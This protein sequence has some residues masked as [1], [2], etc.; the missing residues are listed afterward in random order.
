MVDVLSVRGLSKEY[1]AFRLDDVSFSVKKGSITGFVGRNGAGKTTTLKSILGLCKKSGGDVLFFGLPFEEN[2]WQIKKRIG[3]AGG[4]VNFYP[5]KKIREIVNVTRSFY[6]NFDEAAFARYMEKFSLDVEKCPRELSE[7][8][9]VKLNLALAL[10]HRAEL[11]I[12]DEPTSGLDP[13]S[14]EELLEIFLSLAA[15]GVSILFSTHIVSDL[16]KCA[17]HIVYLQKGGV[18]ID[19]PYRDFAGDY[20]LLRSGAAL[21]PELSALSL[22]CTK[23]RDFFTYLIRKS[24]AAQFPEGDVSS[25]SIEDVIVHLEKE[26]I[27]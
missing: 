3:Y 8:M 2:E 4:A 7:G 5:R 18:K 17:D 13:V 16:E 25:P 20:A 12:L 27:A 6:D 26:V 15:E 9:K 10:S 24:D 11:L 22:G 14:R 23:N 19:K 21:S 1:S